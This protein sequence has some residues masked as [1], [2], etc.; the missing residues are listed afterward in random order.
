MVAYGSNEEVRCMLCAMMFLQR[1]V[2][3]NRLP[4]NAGRLALKI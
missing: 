1:L 2:V 3:F 4:T